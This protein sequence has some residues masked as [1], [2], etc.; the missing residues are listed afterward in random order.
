MLLNFPLAICSSTDYTKVT[1]L[2]TEEIS[3]L[4]KHYTMTTLVKRIAAIARTISDLVSTSL[5]QDAASTS[6]RASYHHCCEISLSA[7]TF[8]EFA[9]MA[10]QLLV[11]SCFVA[12]YYYNAPTTFHRQYIANILPY[13]HPLH[14]QCVEAIMSIEPL[15]TCID[16]IVR[17]LAALDRESI[18]RGFQ[19]DPLTHFYEL[20]LSYY[21]PRLRA[22][23][24]IFYTPEPVVSYMVRSIEQLLRSRFG[25]RDGFGEIAADMCILDPACGT[26]VFVQATLE[27][28]R[29]AYQR[30]EQA[31]LWREHLRQY[32]LPRL[33]GIE[34]LITPYLIAHFR[35]NLFLT[36]LDLPEHGQLGRG[37]ERPALEPGPFRLG[38]ALIGPDTQQQ[39][40]PSPIMIV[41]GNPPYAGH[42][43]NREAWML[44]LLDEYKEGCPE[45][46]K[47]AQA[48]W[49]SDD[50]VKFM[51][52]AQ[53]R[54][55][56]AG[57]GILAFITS[58]SYLDNP[59]FRG[60]RHSLMRSFDELFVLDLH[61]NSKKQE[62]SPGETKDENVF[63]IQPGVAISI[64]VKKGNRSH[65]KG[66]GGEDVGRGPLRSPSSFSSKAI[67]QMSTIPQPLRSPSSSI[68]SAETTAQTPTIYHAQLWG[69]RVE[70]LSWLSSH[71]LES[72]T[73]TIQHP[74]APHYLFAPQETHYFEEYEAGWSL[75]AIFRPNGDPAPGIITCH[76]EFAVAWS[77]DE[78]MRKVERLLATRD[79][80]E[81]RQCYRL[82]AQEQ[83]NYA[84]AKRALSD[85]KWREQLTPVLYRPFDTR[86]TVYNRHVAV[87]LRERV[88]RHMLPGEAQGGRENLALLIGKAGQVISQQTW[89]IVFCSR[90]MTEFNLFRRGGNNIFPLYLA[91]NDRND[92]QANRDV[93]LA[94][95]FIA[96]VISCLGLRWVA[97][98]R[99]D[100]RQSIGPEA[101]FSYMY[102]LLH[103]P[104]YRARYA[105]F[106]KRDFPRIPLTSNLALF[107]AL[108]GMGEKLV[109]L[110]LM[111]DEERFITYYP[112]QGTHQ[113]EHIRYVLCE[114]DETMGRVWINATHYFE[115][116]PLAVWTWHIGGYQ[117]CLKWLKDRMGRILS[118]EEMAHYQNIVA[119]LAETIALM[120]G[121][122]GVIE[123]TGGWP[124]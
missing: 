72:T 77:R 34:V 14:R 58:H 119:V 5:E 87:H 22:S 89:D 98:G 113:I 52:L 69:N 7:I 85:G 19:D 100:L 74:Q 56:R 45:L 121:I 116:V 86:W 103:A 81:A 82:C 101:I 21:N 13:A 16:E 25:C 32:F 79:E 118:R 123:Q 51:R 35:L 97:E 62:L 3:P 2:A 30:N 108:C 71:D 63:A 120:E 114:D 60:M 61:G 80:E 20:F 67:A 9:D 109:R 110:H 104:T 47:R 6:L 73:W 78:A 93:N 41:L 24:G 91:S 36:D 92:G 117:V 23:H 75:P 106:L 42:S 4:Q 76:D 59:T 107:R 83:W 96:D 17:L 102:A 122:D 26:G 64:F 29:A 46:Q 48:K 70:K 66:V 55:D 111:E 44:S 49:L 65:C 112:V 10:S 105:A 1:H 50:Y 15:A 124:L 88:T 8:T 27:R 53:W 68:L 11:Y 31:E 39:D 57:Q 18:D 40:S 90:I 84:A 115:N 37:Q 12:R 94:P 43:A 28:V 99:G 33:L 95:D 38:N 54:I